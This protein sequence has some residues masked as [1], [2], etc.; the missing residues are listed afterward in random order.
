MSVYDNLS[1]SRQFAC[2]VIADHARS[3]AFSIA[4]G[5][6]PGN[7]GRNYVLRKIMRR[8]IYHGREHLGMDGLFFYKVCDKV[9][10]EM[11]GA[12]PELAVQRDFISKMVR[13]E[14]ERFGNTMTVGLG[15][16]GEF[17]FDS[18]V[19][20]D[21][22]MFRKLAKLY[23][24]YGTPRD[25]IRVYLEEKGIAF[26]EEDYNERF[27]NA[28]QE[29]QR[30]SGIGQT[31]RKSD[32]SPIYAQILEKVGPNAF[33]GYDATRFE[34]AEVVTI[35]K[36]D[37]AA[38]ALSQGEQGSVVLN[39]TPFYAESGGQVGDTG[40][41]VT[42]KNDGGEMQA[43]VSDTFSP[44]AGLV[45]H[46]VMVEA[47]ELKVGDKVTAVVDEEKRDATRRNHTA[48]HLVHA[49]LKEVLGTHVKQAGSVVAPSY[50]RFD[51]THYQPM[52]DAEIRE[53]EDLVNRY[54]LQNEPVAT[55]LM[56]LEDAMRSGAVAM[57]GEKYG[58]D[59]R[60]LSVGDGRFSMELCGG[61]HVRATG[62]I[63]SCKILSDEAIASGVR[64]IRAITGLDAFRRFR[65]DEVLIDRS[66]EALKTQRDN[67]PNA[68]ERLQEEV[69]RTRREIEDLKLK[70]ATG[71]VGNGSDGTG[72]DEA[73]EIGGVKVLG[74]IVDGLDANGQRQLSDT[75]LARLKSGV[76]ILGRKDEGKASIIVRVSADLTDRVKA[77]NVVKEIVPIVG[78]RGGGRPDMAEGGGPEPEK[79]DEAIEASFKII[80]TILSS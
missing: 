11:H 52:T 30:Q 42:V 41:L 12:F 54:I 8:A 46:K 6:L 35:L 40:R 74:K 50:L 23:D 7:E 67:L 1:E 27:E 5:I 48:T 34:N 76:V 21:R 58:S 44:V 26:D 51:F 66:L 10:E 65:E 72:G 28:L 20:P 69:K 79:L 9:V 57:F 33:H 63:G 25:L 22:E 36:G 64:R 4:D 18:G 15:R 60:V 61:T 53:I 39:E 14:E 59:V 45:I 43:V 55:N 62:D 49:A 19:E 77:G 73:R 24:T 70:I 13:L 47:G 38:D 80:E 16:L 78:G 75:L 56:A 37:S 17:Q 3:T 2:R 71:A 32:I 68:I 31:H 29:L